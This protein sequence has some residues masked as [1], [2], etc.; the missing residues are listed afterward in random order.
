MPNQHPKGAGKTIQD[1]TAGITPMLPGQPERIPWTWFDTQTY[2]SGTTTVLDFFQSVN[3]DKN[4]SN[5]VAAGQIPSPQFFDMYHTSIAYLVPLSAAALA[6]PIG[7]LGAVNDVD[8]LSQGAALFNVASKDYWQGPQLALPCGGG[9]RPEISS[10]A[11]GTAAT[12]FATIAQYAN[13]GQPDLRNRYN[14][15]GDITLPA[16]QN[17]IWRLTWS[18][19]LTFLPNTNRAIKVWMDGYLYRRVL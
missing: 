1:L 10:S 18:A 11:T 12:P 8:R 3:A 16:N 6:D 15:W 13:N 9:A 19:A 5:M 4:L 17:F 2:V 7:I 14:F